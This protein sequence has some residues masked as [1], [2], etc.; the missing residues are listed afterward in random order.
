M[1]NQPFIH[2]EL[3]SDAALS[4]GAGT[5]GVVDVEVEHDNLGLPFLGGKT[6]RGLLRD[7][8]L[9][10]QH[11]FPELNHTADRIFGPEA[12]LEERSILR[13]GDAVVEKD[14]RAWIRSSETRKSNAIAPAVV[15]EALT[16]I[17]RQTSEDRKSGA[18][19]DRTLRAIRVVIRGLKLKA[20]LLWLET[21][22]PA[23]LRCLNLAMLAT[24]HAGLARNRG[25]G[26]IRLTLDG[27]LEKTRKAVKGGAI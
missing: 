5:A 23:D 19:A 20:P 16:D 1:K 17:R 18:P 27:D 26:H 8:W 13:V 4:R 22:S 7:A 2:V 14:V 21:P 12:D 11:C 9:S 25:R 3:L 10:M 24:R 15:L 6:L